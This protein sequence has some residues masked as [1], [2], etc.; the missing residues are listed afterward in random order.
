M[1]FIPMTKKVRPWKRLSG[2]GLVATSE[3][4]TDTYDSY[5]YKLREAADLDA[6]ATALQRQAQ[7]AV[8]EGKPASSLLQ[9]AARLQKR[10]KEIRTE[11]QIAE[12]NRQRAAQAA[13]ATKANTTIRQTASK[14]KAKAG[15][16]SDPTGAASIKSTYSQAVAD[17]RGSGDTGG[18]SFA[19]VLNSIAE[20][21]GVA[22]PTANQI[23]QNEQQRRSSD[24][25]RR[26]ERAAANG[27]ITSG[28]ASGG[29]G[30]S[31]TTVAYGVGGLV[32]VG[33]SLWAL[34]SL[35]RGSSPSV[36]V[37]RA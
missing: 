5:Q 18:S 6:Q 37:V 24:L 15:W 8:A 28:Q 25:A 2:L 30:I 36:A 27:I 3:N 34:S 23:V 33:V 19:D 26:A 13:N 10:A 11:A 21:I 35:L 9:E 20:V 22:A 1:A 7:V 17:A 32:V 16:S 29:S 14:G 31:S 12:G 4:T